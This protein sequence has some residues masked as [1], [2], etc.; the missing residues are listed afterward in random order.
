MAKTYDPADTNKNGKVSTAERQRYK[1]KQATKAAEPAV[2]AD[3][4][5]WDTLGE[6]YAFVVPLL[7]TDPEMAAI[8]QQAADEGWSPAKIKLALQNTTF[9]KTNN[10]YARQAWSAYQL[11][12]QGA[13]ADWQLMMDDA[14]MAVQKVASRQ[15]SQIPPEVL[16]DIQTKYI[17]EG[18]GKRP[19]GEMLLQ[20]ALSKYIGY[21]KT[22][23]GAGGM[24]LRGSS[25]DIAG[26][27]RR[28]AT[29]NGISYSDG[30][31]QSAAKS[32]AEGWTT[33]NDWQRDIQEQAASMWPVFADKIRA[34]VS[35]QD[36]AS[37]YINL[38]AQ[39]FEVDPNTISLNDPYVR[40]ALGGFDQGGNPSA[41]NLWDFELKLREDP[42]WMTTKQA[43]D[44]TNSIANTVL[45]MFGIRG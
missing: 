41:M 3:T 27:L 34:G 4:L 36:L 22:P 16:K 20:Q 14:K 25:G 8:A 19:D 39:T 21:E 42:R 23:G 24:T 13:S 30:W 38:M 10:K 43:Q 5:D 35:A 7:K 17:Y 11:S 18:W 9:W 32:I 1:A 15:G 28:T 26:S 40:Q 12:Q 33:E 37:P 44:Q 6:E 2:K 45:R 29:A 31:Y